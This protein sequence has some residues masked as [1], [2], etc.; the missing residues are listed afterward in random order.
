MKIG[1]RGGH[2][3][4]AQGAVGMINAYDQMQK[5][6]THVSKLLKDMMGLI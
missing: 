6:Y 5:F 4:K 1:L 3:R 2:S